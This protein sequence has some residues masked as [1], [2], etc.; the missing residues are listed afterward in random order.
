MRSSATSPL[1]HERVRR[2]RRRHTSSSPSTGPTPPI[3]KVDDTL[4]ILFRCSPNP[5]TNA[6]N[7][8]EAHGVRLVVTKPDLVRHQEVTA[9]EASPG[10]RAALR[11]FQPECLRRAAFRPAGRSRAAT[12]SPASVC[13]RR[14]AAR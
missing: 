9:I 10:S 11:S 6:Y 1:G 14:V 3:R 5:D 7:E 12:L 4:V 8:H 2:P 13:G